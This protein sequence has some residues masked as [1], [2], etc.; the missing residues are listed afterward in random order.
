M[1]CMKL[2]VKLGCGSREVG[3]EKP[4]SQLLALERTTACELP[5]KIQ[6]SNEKYRE[7]KKW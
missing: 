4:H 1:S 7:T 6:V 5:Q 2:V 3:S